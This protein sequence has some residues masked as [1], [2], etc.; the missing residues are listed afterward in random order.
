MEDT[1]EVTGLV[2]FSAPAGEYDRRLVLLTRELGRITVFAVGARRPTCPYIAA[3]RTFTFAKFTLYQSRSAY[4]I[5]TAQIVESFDSLSQDFDAVS[6]GTYLLELAG[7]F[8]E[9]NVEMPDTVNLIYVSLKAL[10]KP[11]IP[12][13]LVRRVFELRILQLNGVEPQVFECVYCGKPIKDG[14]FEL[15]KHGISCRECKT[16][17]Y[18]TYVNNSVTVSM[19]YILTVPFTKLYTFAVTEDV[20]RVLG[21]CV[22]RYYRLYV[23]HKFKS[24]EMLEIMKTD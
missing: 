7:Y 23:G 22:D 6:Y 9:E 8:S 19:Q 20:L 24:L 2:S 18:A 13:K 14:Y 21:E 15:K 11:A 3:C 12:K 16:D 17:E 10:L 1:V 4:R 5:R